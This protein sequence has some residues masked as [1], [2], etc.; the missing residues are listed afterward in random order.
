MQICWNCGQRGIVTTL[1]QRTGGYYRDRDCIFCRAHWS[2]PENMQAILNERIRSP[3][4]QRNR[5]ETE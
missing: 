4:I 2:V 5:N 1:I 3:R